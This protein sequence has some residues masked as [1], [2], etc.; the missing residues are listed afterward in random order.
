MPWEAEEEEG[1]E[2]DNIEELPQS[3]DGSDCEPTRYPSICTCF[4]FSCV[5]F[6]FV[7][8]GDRCFQSM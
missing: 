6:W 3:N 2:E 7:T 8:Q 4:L 1:E 5:C